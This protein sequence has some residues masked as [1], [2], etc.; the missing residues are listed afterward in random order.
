MVRGKRLFVH[1]VYVDDSIDG[2]DHAVMGAVIL[3]ERDFPKVERFL[4]YTVEDVVPEGL[5]E[6][7]EFHASALFHGKKP[8]ENIEHDRAVEIIRRAA[9][10][11]QEGDFPV[12][13][14]AVNLRELKK[15]PYATSQALDI[16]FRSS[17]DGIREWFI[18]TSPAD[19]LGLLVCDDT[20]NLLLKRQLK[21]SYREYRGQVVGD[22]RVHC[23]FA[24]Y[25]HDDMYFGDSAYSAGLQTA[26]ICSFIVLRHLQGREDTEFLYDM[27]KD[28]IYYGAMK[29]ESVGQETVGAW[30]RQGRP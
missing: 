24:E 13:Y 20:T 7:F 2:G 3:G 29:P 21:E 1:L 10:I 23:G 11:V 4:A 18:R 28:K 30:A 6:S 14:G 19:E 15:S 12:I 8:F 17:L 25:V 5:Q 27:I 9:S 22:Y 26:D 16:A